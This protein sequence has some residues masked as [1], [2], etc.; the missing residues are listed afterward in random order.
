MV[1]MATTILL[2]LTAV[3]MIVLLVW[4]LWKA[5]TTIV[6]R[7]G[8]I[9]YGQHGNP[10]LLMSRNGRPARDNAIDQF[11][12]DELSPAEEV[13]LQQSFIEPPTRL[14]RE[15]KRDWLDQLTGVTLGSDAFFPFRDSIDRASQSGVRF[16]AQPGGSVRDEV[17]IEA[18]DSYGMVMA[19][20]GTRLFHH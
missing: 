6:N 18:C 3:M 8:L 20:T 16:I 17:V 19:L 9:H 7:M 5:I 1:T 2:L 12:L 10:L 13:L 14:S 11:L 15:E 4:F